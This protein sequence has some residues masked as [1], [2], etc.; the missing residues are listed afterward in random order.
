MYT[1][2][3]G[4]AQPLFPPLFLIYYLNPA[5]FLMISSFCHIIILQSDVFA[6]NVPQHAVTASPILSYKWDWW[7]CLLLTWFDFFKFPAFRCS[8]PHG[9]R[10]PKSQTCLSFNYSKNAWKTCEI[11]A[12]A[13]LADAEGH[14]APGSP[15]ACWVKLPASGI[16]GTKQDR[17]PVLGSKILV[18]SAL[19]VH[20]AG[21]RCWKGGIWTQRS[22]GLQILRAVMG[23]SPS[24]DSTHCFS[25][26][27]HPDLSLPTPWPGHWSCAGY[28]IHPPR[29]LSCSP[30]PPSHL[31]CQGTPGL[32]HLP[33]SP[34]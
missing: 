13:Q 26:R 11:S 8:K 9:L 6:E 14:P 30:Y 31:P 20:L 32:T 28:Q 18:P 23:L 21:L 33:F 25:A 24:P 19:L 2:P 17:V 10:S 4:T 22:P 5:I 15:C 29:V 27:F 34:C 1:C 7:H 16:A 3:G 12:K